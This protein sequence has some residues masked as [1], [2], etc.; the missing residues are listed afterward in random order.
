MLKIILITLVIAAIAL[1][2]GGL[3]WGQFSASRFHAL[4]QGAV[5]QGAVVD[6]AETDALPPAV[7][8]YFHRVLKDGQ[9]LIN[10]AR[11]IQQGGFRARPEQQQWSKMTARQA[12]ST[13][14]RAFVWSAE[15]AMLPGVSIKVLDSFM[16]GR[17][18]M[19]GKVLSLITLIESHDRVELDQ[20][21]LQRY[22]AEAVWF[23]TALLPSQ[24]VE[25]QALDTRTARATISESGVSAALDFEFNELGEVISVYAPARYR[26]VDGDFHATPWRGYFSDYREVNGYR[27]PLQGRVEWQLEQGAYPYWRANVTE[28]IYE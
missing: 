13:R 23:P 20:G 17:G 28:L 19:T 27:V 6:L 24:G 10:R 14:P 26:E 5:R 9:P 18:A 21:A 12:F 2:L 16:E 22:L 15:I 4:E 8:T 25:W 1:W 11:L 3:R 7:K